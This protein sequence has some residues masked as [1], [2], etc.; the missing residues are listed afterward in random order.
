[1][2]YRKTHLVLLFIVG[3]F[4]CDS[5]SDEVVGSGDDCETNSNFIADGYDYCLNDVNPS[6]S[7]EGENISPSYYNNK[8]TVHYF[9]HQN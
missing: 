1:M 5:D 7:D 9:G 8:V 6:S 4:G 2:Q 3:F